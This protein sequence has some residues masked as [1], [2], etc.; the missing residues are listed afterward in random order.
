MG[1]E[2]T[3]R[4]RVTRGWAGRCID[5]SRSP[6]FKRAG[7][8]KGPRWERGGVGEGELEAL[9]QRAK[10]DRARL[11]AWPE[12][13]E[14]SSGYRKVYIEANPGPWRCRYCHRRLRGE[15]D[16]TVDH[17]VP[18][19]AVSGGAGAGRRLA[20]AVLDLEGARTVN[21]GANLCPACRRCNSR[22]G[23]KVGM[24][25]LRGWLGRYR[26]W[27][28]AVRAAQAVLLAAAAWALWS[29]GPAAA[30]LARAAGRLL[31]W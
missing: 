25:T 26:A 29:L 15:A 3:Y 17:I 11:E 4:V 8:A 1:D 2:E 13:Y 9:R 7:G 5:P 23:S 10:A 6:G 14:R 18:V 27:W 12:R 21:D 30:E 16:M 24:W 28:L 19:S 31:R 20:R 22:K